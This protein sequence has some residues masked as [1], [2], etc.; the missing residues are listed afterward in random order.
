[1]RTFDYTRLTKLTFDSTTLNYIAKI[2]E[3]KGKQELFIRQKP[4]ELKRLVEVAKIQ[5]THSSNSIEGIKTTTTRMKQL[6]S[7]KTTPRDRDEEE[8]IGYKDVLDTIHENHDSIK[9]NSNYILQLH[10][11]LLSHTS[12]SY[13]GKFKNLQ[14]Y[15]TETMSDGNEVTRFTPLAPY[16]TPIAIENICESY[17]RVRSLELV[18]SLI[19][20]PVFIIDFLCIHPFNDGNGR[21]SR[22]LT[23]LLLY[24][25]G[26][27]VGKYIS[28]EKIIE[29]NKDLY[30]A[31]LDDSDKGWHEEKND[32]MPFVK[33]F[34][35]I[36][37]AAYKE[38]E[39][40]VGNIEE[41]GA[42]SSVYDVV[43]AYVQT[44]IGKFTGAEVINDC[45]N[46]GRSSVLD[47]LKKLVEEG[48]IEKRG[49]G[50]A[51]YYVRI[52]SKE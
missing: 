29:K 49:T 31:A 14:N 46:G 23:L 7:E 4:V 20:I 43:K 50:R 13:G 15:I 9:I 5:S 36:L 30:Y 3:Y 48:I 18:D 25:N 32:P 37:L 11:I 1:M 22:L 6:L 17:N 44:K 52:D 45:P 10:K 16:E 27:L 39:E 47:S 28:I 41:A 34:L 21:M 35:K 8:I 33:Y 42:K 12:F 38:F 40:R 19:L 51:T 2:N 24:Q 26:F